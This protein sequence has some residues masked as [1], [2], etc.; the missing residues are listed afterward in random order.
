[1]YRTT[2]SKRRSS[3][4]DALLPR[5]CPGIL[6]GSPRAFGYNAVLL[7]HVA[8]FYRFHN[9]PFVGRLWSWPATKTSIFIVFV[10]LP[11]PRCRA[12]KF[13]KFWR[14]IVIWHGELSNQDAPFLSRDA[15]KCGRF[16]GEILLYFHQ[17]MALGVLTTSCH[18]LKTFLKLKTLRT[19]A[20][21]DSL[22]ALVLSQL[23]I[24]R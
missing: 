14:M 24:F 17:T 8:Q 9:Y 6:S 23:P 21:G 1:M 2:A 18:W 7:P 12:L 19:K 3:V 4:L 20:A 10:E 16:C 22:L 15:F 13:S 11:P 5:L